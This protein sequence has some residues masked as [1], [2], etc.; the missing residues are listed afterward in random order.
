MSL[1]C[2]EPLAI[3]STVEPR[4]SNSAPSAY[5]STLKARSWP[6]IV[7]VSSL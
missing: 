7:G 6:A 3:T 1:A 5:D 4:F 2:R